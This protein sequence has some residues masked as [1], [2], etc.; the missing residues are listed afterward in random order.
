MT[1]TVLILSLVLLP[2]AVLAPGPACFAQRFFFTFTA[3]LLLMSKVKCRWL[4]ALMCYLVCHQAYASVGWFFGWMTQK[5]HLFSMSAFTYAMAGILVYWLVSEAELKKEWVYNAICVATLVQVA[6]CL[7]QGIWSIDPAL[8]FLKLYKD[9]VRNHF[10]QTIL[11]GSLGNPNFMAAWFAFTLTFF[12]RARWKWCLLVVVPVFLA[13]RSEFAIISAGV[14]L[15]VFCK[16]P[17]PRLDVAYALFVVGFGYLLI[18]AHGL[19]WDWDALWKTSVTTRPENWAIAW[20]KITTPDWSL[21]QPALFFGVG[22]GHIDPKYPIHNDYYSVVFRWGLTAL[23]L[24]LGFLWNLPRKSPVLVAA[25]AA[26]LVNGLASYP[27]RVPTTAFLGCVIFGLMEK[28][29]SYET[30]S[31]AF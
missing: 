31:T 19:S 26:L 28:E 15:I 12:F 20:S 6:L 23:W 21:P 25:F 13:T 17:H 9:N 18:R 24:V 16:T 1:Q 30:T 4:Q 22:Y 8:E 14:G 10:E 7:V 27:L 29:K 5:Q 11:L 2:L 3:W